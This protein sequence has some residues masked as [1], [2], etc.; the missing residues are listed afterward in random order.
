MFCPSTRLPI[1]PIIRLLSCPRRSLS[2]GSIFS[3][4]KPIPAPPPL[5]VAKIAH[6]EA[7]ANANPHDV[8]KQ[9]DLFQSL[10]DTSVKPGYDL[11]VTRWERICELVRSVPLILSIIIFL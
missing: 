7:E 9:L 4:P 10:V 3:R 5:T 1:S 2:L 8:S 11:V 6:L